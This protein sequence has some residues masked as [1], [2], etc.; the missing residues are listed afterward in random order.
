V[1]K[2]EFLNAYADVK[3]KK[4]KWRDIDVS[5]LWLKVKING[6]EG[7]VNDLEDFF[8]LGLIPSG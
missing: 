8:T 6:R 2:V 5:N 1:K 7:W 4:D 3:F